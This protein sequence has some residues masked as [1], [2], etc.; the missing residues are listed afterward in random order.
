M[1]VLRQIPEDSLSAGYITGGNLLK[2]SIQQYNDRV[3]MVTDATRD[4]RAKLAQDL[5][6]NL[7]ST[8]AL[9]YLSQAVVGDWASQQAFNRELNADST[10]IQR[11]VA[12]AIKAGI[13][14]LQALGG[15]YGGSPG[16][17]PAS[18]S[19][20]LYTQAANNARSTNMSLATT[21]ITAL[22]AV[23]GGAMMLGKGAPGSAAKSISK[24]VFK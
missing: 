2:D 9:D 12:D 11:A 10:K 13:N 16:S 5:G 23:F 15:M 18:I 6:M 3:A 21:L 14:P 4:S 24:F 8:E 7:D 17:A 1:A 22:L 19:G 20:G